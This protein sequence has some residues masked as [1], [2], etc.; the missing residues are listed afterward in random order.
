MEAEKETRLKIPQVN[1]FDF[2]VKYS[3]TDR[4]R[5]HYEITLHTHRELEIYINLSGDV[6]F[7]V[8][9][10]LYPLSRGDVIIARPGEYHHCVYRSDR[11]HQLYWILFDSEANR[12]LLDVLQG[13]FTE[14]FISP[15]GHDREELLELCRLLQEGNPTEEEKIY[16]FLR[17]FAILKANRNTGKISREEM[18]EELGKIVAYIHDN[19]CGELLVAELA[20][21]FYI[22][23]STLERMFKAHLDITPLEF[24]RR[25]K[26]ALAAELLRKGD[27]VLEA[28]TAVGYND[29]SYFIRLFR[30]HYGCSPLQYKKRG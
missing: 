10:T 1:A 24:I 2:R 27:S 23:Q 28:G 16:A 26:L 19:I 11:E 4:K 18:P 5:H 14:N 6:S 9:N 17:M 29:S 8:G 15:D 25:K 21:V 13:D 20:K 12:G 3:A 22:S 7:L 30:Q